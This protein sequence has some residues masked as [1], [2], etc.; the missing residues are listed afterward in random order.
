MLAP[1][2]GY[3]AFENCPGVPAS[4]ADTLRG[5][6]TTGGGEGGDLLARISLKRRDYVWTPGRYEAPEEWNKSPPETDFDALCELQFELVDWLVTRKAGHLYVHCAAVEMGPGLV[7]FPSPKRAGKSTLIIQLAEAGFRV[8][9]DDA[10]P[11]EPKHRHGVAPGI[12]PRLRLPLARAVGGKLR[13]FI[14]A[15][16]G[17]A[18]TDYRYV[19]LSD[20]ELAPYGAEAPIHGLVVLDRVKSGPAVLS[21]VGQAEMLKLIIERNDAESALA[22][23]I[24][25][26]FHAITGFAKRFRLTYSDGED[27]VDLLKRTFAV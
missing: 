7:V 11:I 10:L 22:L 12:L 9:A 4:L 13:D 27:A 6:G 8:F 15:R 16:P 5:W 24:F 17:P 26:G 20:R 19:A 18:D 3:L 25:T 1:L 14:D 21:P 2:G 23:E